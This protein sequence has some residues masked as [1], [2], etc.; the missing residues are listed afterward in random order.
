MINSIK[1]ITFGKKIFSNKF[2]ITTG[3]NYLNPQTQIN[4][5]K[6]LIIKIDFIDGYERPIIAFC[7][8]SI[9]ITTHLQMISTN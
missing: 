2:N 5:I 4:Y 8:T 7:K 3:L 6:R 9:S 1:S